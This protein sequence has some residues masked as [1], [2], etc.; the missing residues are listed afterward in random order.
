[1]QLAPSEELDLADASSATPRLDALLQD[2]PL[3]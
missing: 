3:A 2:D 1:V